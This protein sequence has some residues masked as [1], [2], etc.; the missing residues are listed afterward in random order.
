L[1]QLRMRVRSLPPGSVL[2]LIAED[3]GAIEDIPAWCRLTGNRLLSSEHPR[4]L[5]ERK[6]T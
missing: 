4:Y 1:L 5:I 6:P 2:C 3:R